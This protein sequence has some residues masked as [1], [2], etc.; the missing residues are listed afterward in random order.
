MNLRWCAFTGALM[1]LS[2]GFTTLH[3]GV[4][5][6]PPGVKTRWWD[7]TTQTVDT[8]HGNGRPASHTE[9]SDD[10]RTILVQQ[11]W[12]YE[13]ALV[14]SA[15]RH[16]NGRFEVK[17]FTYD[18]K[19]LT[20]HTLWAGDMSYFLFQRAYYRNGQ[21][22]LEEINT[23]D[24]MVTSDRRHFNEDGTL[25]MEYHIL[26]NADQE[27]REYRDGKLF[28][29][30][31]LRGSGDR[32]TTTFYPSGTMRSFQK[33]VKL[34]GSFRH[35]V[36][37]ADGTLQLRREKPGDSAMLTVTVYSRGEQ[38]RFRQSY[39]SGTLTEVIEY[40]SQTGQ[41][42]RRLLVRNGSTLQVELFRPDGTLAR[43]KQLANGRV[44]RQITYDETGKTVTADIQG[45]EVE[46]VNPSLIADPFQKIDEEEE[47]N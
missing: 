37:R 25:Q 13:G 36:F 42:A 6:D 45:G 34:D 19:V 30:F 33:A 35:D 23:E 43:K 28:K 41:P 9:L 7:G 5:Q 27:T 38:A 14:Y 46:P 12:S 39:D 21:L 31:L 22:M 3:L 10:G 29:V 40:S 16:K 32:E 26:K 1:L 4:A 2:V 24:G 11:K 18:G 47:S 20:S 15:Q 8:T 44:V 17:E